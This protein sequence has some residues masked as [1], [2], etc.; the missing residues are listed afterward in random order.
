MMKLS[1]NMQ[2][3]LIDET[4]FAIRRMKDTKE[5]SM[6]LYFFSAVYGAVFRVFNI[7]FDPELL[8][9]HQVLNYAYGTINARVTALSQGQERGVAIPGGLFDKLEEALEV[10]ATNIEENKETYPALQTIVRLA[11][12]T[13]GNGYYLYLKNWLTVTV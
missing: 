1:K 6:K 5:A 13:T 10:M 7:E 3:V 8:F 12:S 9:I 2:K 4:R 11:Y